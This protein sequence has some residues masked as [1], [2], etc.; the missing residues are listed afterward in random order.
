[1]LVDL[2][3]QAL[4]RGGHLGHGP[5]HASQH[6]QLTLVGLIEIRPGGLGT[7]LERYYQRRA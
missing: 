7:Y 4:A 1:L 6:L 2:Q 5:A 3:L